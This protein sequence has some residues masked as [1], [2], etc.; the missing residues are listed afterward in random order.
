MI[1]FYKGAW[2]EE[3]RL[4]GDEPFLLWGMSSFTTFVWEKGI[5]APD[6]H[7]KRIV[8]GAKYLGM[9]SPSYQSF[10]QALLQV[11][12]K[13]EEQGVFAKV[14]LAWVQGKQD[15]FFWIRFEGYSEST[16]VSL[17]DPK[18]LAIVELNEKEYKNSIR[19]Y[20]VGNYAHHRKAFAQKA[21]KD[22]S[23]LVFNG[24]VVEATMASII[25]LGEGV[26][27]ISN[28][29]NRL[30]SIAEAQLINFLKYKYK[31]ESGVKIE[32]LLNQDGLRW[33]YCNSLQGVVPISEISGRKMPKNEKELTFLKE[34]ALFSKKQIKTLVSC[35]QLSIIDLT[36]V[37]RD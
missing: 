36:E 5:C 20:K 12:K 9:E 8:E 15:C 29:E 28:S 26:V 4:N 11:Q 27:F 22:D 37:A 10:L 1:H 21:E 3:L 34:I 23:I 33:Y 35:S 2:V 17:S 6:L 18:T 7:Y 19:N 14:R 24:S 13:S 25:V 16:S 31:V 32:Q 30:E